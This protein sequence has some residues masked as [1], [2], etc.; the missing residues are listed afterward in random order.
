MLHFNTTSVFGVEGVGFLG[1]ANDRLSLTPIQAPD[2]LFLLSAGG[3]NSLALRDAESGRSSD[4][5]LSMNAAPVAQSEHFGFDNLSI[6]SGNLPGVASN[7]FRALLNDGTNTFTSQAT[8]FGPLSGGNVQNMTTIDV[9][10]DGDLDALIHGFQG[11]NPGTLVY[12]NDGT[13]GFTQSS[14][15]LDAMGITA[16]GD[17]NGDGLEDIISI[18]EH[19]ASTSTYQTRLNNGDG[20]FTLQTTTANPFFTGPLSSNITSTQGLELFDI[21]GDGD[22]DGLAFGNGA[23]TTMIND[24]AGIFTL[25]TSVVSNI[26]GGDVGDI[27]GDGDLDLVSTL[28]TDGGS[29]GNIVYVRLNDGSGGFPASP[30]ATFGASTNT[31]QIAGLQLLDW[32]FDGDLDAMVYGSGNAFV[33]LNDGAGN[34]S[35]G[36]TP[37]IPFMTIGAA[38]FGNFTGAPEVFAANLAHTLDVLAN[39][40]DADA[41]DTLTITEVD[42]QAIT[43]GGA[44]ITLAS[45]AV[46]TLVGG[47]LVYDGAAAAA[48]SALT[49][50]AFGFDSFTYTVSDG[51]GGMDTETVSLRMT[52]VNDLPTIT[53]PA[54]ITVDEDSSDNAVT[55]FSVADADGDALTVMLSADGTLS[56]D[57]A[58]LAGLTFETGDGTDDS[59]MTFSGSVAAI[60]A[61]LATLTYDPLADDDDGDS[62]AIT[63]SDGTQVQMPGT[64]AA[65]FELSSLLAANGGDGSLGFVLNGVDSSDNSGFS[66]SDAGDVNGDGIDDIIIGASFA[67]PGGESGA[68]ESYVVFGSD[69]GFPANLE[70]STLDGSNGFVIHGLDEGDLSGR[71][72]S[73]AG[74]VNGDGIDDLIIGA[75]GADPG[76]RSDAGESYIVFG[77]DQ[78]F[79]PIL[80]DDESLNGSNGFMIVGLDSGDTSGISVSSAGDVNGDGIDDLII[81]A[82]SADPNGDSA[83]GETYVVFGSDQGFPSVLLDNETLTGSNGFVINGI[84]AN[85]LSGRSVSSAGD[86]NGD[87]IDDL[88]IGAWQAD[89]NGDSLAGESY[90]VF[91][92]DQGFAASLDLSALNGSNGFVINGIDAGDFSGFSVSS[93]GD[94]NGDGISD[95]IIGAPNADNGG[96]NDRGESYIIFGSVQGFAASLELSALNGSNGFVLNGIDQSDQSGYSVSSAGD[97]N[98][99]G[100]DDVII[101]ARFANPG[102]NA[103]AGESYVVFGSDQG[104]SA[105]LDLSTLNG[106][107]GFVINGID[108]IDRS[109]VSV[110]AAGDVNGDGVDDLIIGAHEADPGGRGNAGESYVIFGR[111]DFTDAVTTGAIGVNIT[112]ANDAPAIGGDLQI[113]VA[114]NGSVVLTTADLTAIDVDD[115]A[116]DLTFTVTARGNGFLFTTGGDGSEITSFTQADLEAGLVSFQQDGGEQNFALVNLT[117]MDAGGLTSA[118]ATLNASVSPVN[119]IPTLTGDLEAMLAEGGTYVLTTDDVSAVDPDDADADLTFT[120]S[121][122]VNGQVLVSGL[123]AT[124]FTQADLVAGLVAYQH[125][126]SITTFGSFQLTAVDDAGASTGAPVTFDAMITGPNIIDGT[127]GDDVLDGTSAN[128]ILTA[129]EGDDVLRGF[130]GADILVAGS[131]RD[132]LLGGADADRYLLSSGDN[133]VFINEAGG[134]ANG[135]VTDVIAMKPGFIYNLSMDRTGGS[136]DTLRIQDQVEDMSVSVFNHFSTVQTSRGIE[137][138]IVQGQTFNLLAGITG[139]AGD[140]VMVGDAANTTL[141]GGDGVDL[142][143]ANLTGKDVLRGQDG[144][145]YMFAGRGGRD[146]MLGGDGSDN[147]IVTRGTGVTLINEAA[148]SDFATTTDTLY[149]T[150]TNASTLAGTVIGDSLYLTDQGGGLQVRLFRQLSATDPSRAIEAVQLAD[151]SV[152]QI[153]LDK[154]GIGTSGDDLMVGLGGTVIDA[155]AGDDL[156]LAS[157]NADIF[158]FDTGD[159]ADIITRFDIDEDVIDL[160]DAG[161]DDFTALQALIRDEAGDTLIDFGDGDMITLVGVTVASLTADDFDF[162]L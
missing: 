153:A 143:F 141:R 33:M 16:T 137:D 111:A 70:L 60:N 64:F 79:P 6:A 155:G 135:A 20:S 159:G 149:L 122:L 57:A 1:T 98:G 46:V 130:A 99:D 78:G 151:G 161:V 109:G 40:T 32:D 92:S 107:N 82:Q 93:A 140:D 37:I 148:S 76:G 5:S 74:D 119:D 132:K 25:G 147:Y 23:I 67:D 118:Q 136:G 50:G 11:L 27:D 7:A 115:T 87:G 63:V 142:L 2:P 90:V 14:T 53:A 116:A 145:D 8:L 55:G 56:F 150:E 123:A 80:L 103:S 19:L 91:G 133:D 131:G 48:L 65:T 125:D 108:Q 10:S 43:D 22:L 4:N 104:F 81:G 71:A 154:S 129:L 121:N 101:G 105:S 69:Q 28:S 39:D 42:G 94:F 88:I 58:T 41:G 134:D 12:L 124:S 52:G 162:G 100:F 35:D 38:T 75:F 66:V 47:Q 114:E 113:A 49:P 86:I 112:A 120:V 152:Y 54:S 146:V 158:N 144:D 126:G 95:V 36:G 18:G 31:S 89:P 84:D 17:V 72:V 34:F 45:G 21:D 61:A 30:S 68:G 62:I 128:D 138:L 139:T 117:V 24:G 59:L 13:G 26:G 83:A 85:D 96:S 160:A 157:R 29:G 127:S 97:I 102:G 73:S 3:F 44:G 77:S 156:I 106:S 110:S 15:K 9:D 51:M